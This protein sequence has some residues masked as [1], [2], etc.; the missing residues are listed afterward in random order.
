MSEAAAGI[1][2]VLCLL[3]SV[4][5]AW[6]LARAWRASRARLLLFSAIC[7]ALLSVNNIFVVADMIFV[8]DADLTV[9]RQSATVAAL[10]V[11]LYGFIWEAE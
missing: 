3:T 7:F 1:V 6:L 11:L 9:F 4:V 2:Y 5:C 8:K 10:A